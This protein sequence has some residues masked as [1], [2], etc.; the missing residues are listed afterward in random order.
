MANTDLYIGVISGTSVDG[1]DCALVQFDGDQ[2]TLLDTL[3]LEMDQSLRE[4][5][6]NLC[7]GEPVTLTSL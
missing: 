2:P 6:L 5:I 4:L 1:V 7:S 3:F